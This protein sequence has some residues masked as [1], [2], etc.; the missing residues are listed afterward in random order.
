LRI[1]LAPW[2][3]G[4]TGVGILLDSAWKAAS[5]IM[6]RLALATDPRRSPAAAWGVAAAA[7]GLHRAS[8]LPC[9]GPLGM[10]DILEHQLHWLNERPDFYVC[11]TWACSDRLLARCALGAAESKD[12]AMKMTTLIAAACIIGTPAIAVAASPG[13][14]GYAPGQEMHKK[15]AASASSFAPGHIK[16]RGH[17]AAEYSPGDRMNDARKRR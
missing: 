6:M 12:K 16:R 2:R 14:S 8:A 15:G 9:L 1:T 11:G 5:R 13:A 3:K 10:R 7:E 4:Q 17:S